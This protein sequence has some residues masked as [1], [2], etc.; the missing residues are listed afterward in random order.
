MIN[1]PLGPKLIMQQ[2]ELIWEIVNNPAEEAEKVAQGWHLHPAESIRASG[3]VAP[4]TGA[5]QVIANL[6]KQIEELQAQQARLLPQASPPE[7]P[8]DHPL[9]L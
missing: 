8:K 3:K 1:T 5:D 2:R 7:G 6:K 4:A 9:S